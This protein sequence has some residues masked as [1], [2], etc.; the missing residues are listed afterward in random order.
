MERMTMHSEKDH[1]WERL[2]DDLP[3]SAGRPAEQPEFGGW[4]DVTWWAIGLLIAGL[5]LLG[6]ATHSHKAHAEPKGDGP[7]VTLVVVAF[8]GPPGEEPERIQRQLVV[9]SVAECQAYI[10]AQ[11]DAITISRPDVRS[12]SASCLWTAE[13][14]DL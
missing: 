9:S 5:F 3:Y 11:I 8:A 12:V 14:Q 13:G 6:L 2:V 4:R 1:D 10:Q 7:I